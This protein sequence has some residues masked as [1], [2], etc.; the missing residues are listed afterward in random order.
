MTEQGLFSAACEACPTCR[1][2]NSLQARECSRKLRSASEEKWPVTQ[3][4]SHWQT[5]PVPPYLHILT[6]TALP[7]QVT[8]KEWFPKMPCVKGLKRTRRK[9]WSGRL[10]LNQ[11]PHAPQACAL[12]GCATSRPIVLQRVCCSPPM[13]RRSSWPISWRIPAP[14][15]AGYNNASVS[16]GFEDRQ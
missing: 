14:K 6:T 10:D 3:S 11:R 4:M 12:P 13:K 15:D 2:A 7:Q 8:E 1:V 5:S 9:K 16:L